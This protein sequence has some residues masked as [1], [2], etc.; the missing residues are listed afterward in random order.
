MD[1]VRLEALSAEERLRLMD[2][3]LDSLPEPDDQSLSPARRQELR[4]RL[5]KSRVSGKCGVPVREAIALLSK[6]Q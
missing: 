4:D 3:I 2:V 5:A 1:K 6:D